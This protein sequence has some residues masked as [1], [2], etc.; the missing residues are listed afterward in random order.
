MELS[1]NS[2]DSYQKSEPEHQAKKEQKFEA[3]EDTKRRIFQKGE[4]KEIKFTKINVSPYPNEENK[5]LFKISYHQDYK[6]FL[7][8]TLNYYSNGN[9]E[10]YVELKNGKMQILVE[11]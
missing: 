6:A 5:K 4:E 1:A 10:L 7:K 9:K 3:F 2:G 8:G 11:Q